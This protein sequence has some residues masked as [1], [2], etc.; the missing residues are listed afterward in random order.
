[1]NRSADPTPPF[2]GGPPPVGAAPWHAGSGSGLLGAVRRRPRGLSQTAPADPRRQPP[3][4]RTEKEKAEAAEA[5]PTRQTG[6]GDRGHRPQARGEPAG[7]P[8]RD[9]R[10]RRR[11]AR[12][13]RRADIAELQTRVPNLVD[14][15]R[16]N[17]STTL[18]A[19]LRG[20]GQPDPLWGARSRRRPLPRRRLHRAPAGRAARR[21]RC[22]SDRGAARA[23]G[24]AL[25]QEHDRRRDQVR[26][27]ADRRRNA[28][29]P[30]LGHRRRR[31]ADRDVRAGFAAPGGGQGARQAPLA[32]LQHD[33][34]G[35]NLYTGKDVSDKDT[36]AFR[37]GFDWLP[38][39]AVKVSL[40]LRLHQDDAAAEGAD[41]P[42]GQPVLPALPR[43]HLSARAEHLRHP[44]RSRAAQRHH[45]QGYSGV[46]AWKISDAWLF[47]SI[48]AYRES[49]SDNNIDFDTTPAPIA[50]VIRSTYY[51]EQTSQEFQL[52]YEAGGEAH[53]RLRRLLLP[54][55]RRGPGR[56]RLLRL[57][58]FDHRRQHQSPSRSPSSATAATP[59]PTR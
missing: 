56:Q 50:D 58:A 10:A 31:D 1:M 53:R 7:G 36:M 6:G 14:L 54:R 9:H 29:A 37:L 5:D 59:S 26:Q 55:R 19:F 21:L 38:S 49:D 16:R 40:I 44:E 17:Q 12:G 23:A 57:D 18:T 43:R 48:T 47:K 51:D 30:H 27:P 8:G 52:V 24:H 28:A 11:G 34:Y 42:A 32:S 33:G 3:P 35:K 13:E 22:R 4:P 45:R 46:V 2:S 15:R 20:V 39:D 41:P 25:R